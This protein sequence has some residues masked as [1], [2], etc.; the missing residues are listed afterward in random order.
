MNIFSCFYINFNKTLYN[1][2]K[3]Y[4]HWTRDIETENTSMK[5]S[6]L[7]GAVV[8]VLV[9]IAGAYMLWPRPAI[10]V[11]YMTTTTN[12]AR[13]N[14][15]FNVTLLVK[16][17]GSAVGTYT[18][19]LKLD[20][21]V[22][23]TTTVNIAAGETINRTYVVSFNSTGQ[24][25][26]N[27]GSQTKTVKIINPI[28]ADV[29]ARQ[30]IAYAFDADTY[31]A[32]ILK[33]AG[34]QPNSAIPEGLFGYNAEIPR[35][36]YN[37]TKASQ[38]L[39]AVAA[40]YGFSTANPLKLTLYYN[41]GNSIREKFCLLISSAVNSLN[42][43]LVIDVQSVAWPQFLY[44]R[45]NGLLPIFNLGW[46][47]DY[48]DP[49]DYLVPFYH[50]QKGTFPMRTGWSNPTVD[51]LV[52]QQA[53]ILNETERLAMIDQINMLVYQDCPYVWLAQ[54]TGIHFERTWMEGWYYNPAYSG[55]YYAPMSKAAGADNPN[56]IY[57]ATTGEPQYVDPSVDYESAGG[58]II[59]QVYERLFWFP[60]PTEE[61]PLNSDATTV[62]PWLASG[63][64]VT[65]DGLT[66]TIY[67][68]E[69]I[70]FSD[71]TPF[72]ATAVKYSLERVVIMSDPNGPGWCIDPI[73]GAADLRNAVWEGTA[74][75]DDVDAWSASGAI[76]I[77]DDYTVN[78][79]LDYAYSP[80]LKVLAYSVCAIVSPTTV[81]A[82]GGVVIGAQNEWMNRHAEAGTGPYI[83]ETWDTGVLSLIRNENYWGG[84]YNI[85]ANIERVIIQ[86]I[87]D[88]NTRLTKLISG[89]TDFAAIDRATWFS[90]IN[91]TLWEGSQ[92]VVSI[93]P[94]VRAI[95]PTPSLNI[96]FL[97]ISLR[98]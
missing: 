28:F 7:I 70:F 59:E 82:N 96:D 6:Y 74:T 67:L 35:Y 83:L 25:S 84:P 66:Y 21:V 76:T 56:V 12:F 64:D 61:D 37:L 63:Y 31:I 42:T 80:F 57:V 48:V 53:T 18:L 27:A 23:N 87:S 19:D 26:I 72:N 88:G 29:R 16:N 1:L 85:T 13:A 39:T 22:K 73:M 44:L 81:E 77:V 8:V 33:G 15:Q 90:L 51:S 24:H 10:D 14:E 92:T 46:M 11:T 94:N 47:P 71:G 3:S 32:E 49:D 98:F 60:L 89:E 97:G 79:T 62:I 86:D 75:Q 54:P 95:G 4:N 50:S 17:S 38:L 41:T 78:I 45:D 20:N 30:A 43:G 69:G 2:R 55:F 5:T 91:Q 40:D 34:Q 36:T 58:E 52:D 9:V 65:P 68:R 93:D